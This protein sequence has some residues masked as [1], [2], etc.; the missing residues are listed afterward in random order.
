VAAAAGDAGAAAKPKMV[1]N[2]DGLSL[3]DRIAKRQAE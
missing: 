1:A 2:P 3:A